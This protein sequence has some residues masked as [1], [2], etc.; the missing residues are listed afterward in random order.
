M[1]SENGINEQS[2]EKVQQE[3]DFFDRLNFFF[4]LPDPVTRY[5]F[6]IGL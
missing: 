6:R 1:I 3:L 5:N 4:T 2:V